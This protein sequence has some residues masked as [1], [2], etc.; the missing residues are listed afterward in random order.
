[1]LTLTLL[2][3]A[4]LD[5]T[6][7]ARTVTVG[8]GEQLRTT[9]VGDGAEPVVFIAG[10]FGGAF[11]YRHLTTPLAE[12][13]YRCIVIEPLG[14]GF[15]SHPSKSDYSFTAQADRIG[16]VLDSLGVTHAIVIAQSSASSMAYRLAY[17]RP[18]LVRGVLSISGG[19]A[20]TPAT[21][22]LKRS[23]RF[24]GFL[25]KLVV[26]KGMIRGKVKKDLI[27][28]SGDTT[29]VTEQTVGE[30][31]AGQAEDVDGAIDGLRRMSQAIEPESLRERLHEMRVPIRLLVGTA[32]H[33]SA[34]K[35]DE[36]DLMRTQI[37]DFE[38]EHIEGSGQ[39]I[40]EEQPAAVVAA[41]TRLAATTSA[42]R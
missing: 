10:I 18:E 39:Y 38:V 37:A 27:K 12:L 13:G 34:V 24:G 41:F 22:V 21:P 33:A 16:A 17:R 30:Y 25:T 35:E 14:F 28:N 26:G 42:L 40:H 11:G 4:T 2:L 1:M 9:I 23:L 8:P 20:E 5:T 7:Q 36:I 29:W 3:L 15:S 32:P 6:A 31:T 19:P